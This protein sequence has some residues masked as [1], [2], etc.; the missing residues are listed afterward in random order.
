MERDHHADPY[1]AAGPVHRDIYLPIK[2]DGTM[3]FAEADG[4]LLHW[5]GGRI[6]LDIYW[7]HLRILC[8]HEAVAAGRHSL[9][10]GGYRDG[11]AIRGGES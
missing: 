4:L 8:S 10:L 6:L 7:E 5:G 9:G 1:D 3:A 2:A 11:I